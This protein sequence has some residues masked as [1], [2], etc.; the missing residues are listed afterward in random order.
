VL[1]LADGERLEVAKVMAALASRRALVVARGAGLAASGAVLA[2]R[3]PSGIYPEVEFPRIVVVARGGDAP[4]DVT[5]VSIGRPLETAL[6]TVLGVERVRA[7]AIRGAVELSL[8]FSPGMDMWR[9]LQ[10]VESRIGDA[11]SSLPGRRGDRDRAPDD[12]VVPGDHVQPQRQAR[13]A[14]AA[15]ILASWSCVRPS[16]ASPAW[17]AWRSWAATCARWRWCSTRRA[18]RRCA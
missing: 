6:A 13:S 10:L 1:G 4:P 15:R 16:R 7:R 5:Q 14:P 9:A 11:R 3:M 18:R 2:S 8:L 12:D 17:A